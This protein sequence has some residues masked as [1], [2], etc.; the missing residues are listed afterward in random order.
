MGVGEIVKML[1][2]VVSVFN[3]VIVVSVRGI[4]SCL[5]CKKRRDGCRSN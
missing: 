2:R 1:S 4:S 3:I 5:G